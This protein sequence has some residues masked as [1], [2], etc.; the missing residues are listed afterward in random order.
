MEPP[1]R[2]LIYRNGQGPQTQLP[3]DLSAACAWFAAAAAMCG[4]SGRVELYE[5]LN[6]LEAWDGEAE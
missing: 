1:F 4:D 5:G 2:I 3:D 6:L